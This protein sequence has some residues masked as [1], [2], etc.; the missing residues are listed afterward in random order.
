M[1]MNDDIMR[2][3]SLPWKAR[4]NELLFDDGCIVGQFFSVDSATD[5]GFDAKRCAYTA[6]AANSFPK[7]VEAVRGL[8]EM[9]DT[10]GFAEPGNPCWRD[11]QIIYHAKAALESATTNKPEE[12][13]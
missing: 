13:K 12:P 8:L 10:Y 7:L 1:P 5:G 11:Q 4:D 9:F 6:R 2:G 3:I